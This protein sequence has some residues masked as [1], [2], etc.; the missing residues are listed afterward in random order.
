MS[1][2][3]P[4]REIPSPPLRKTTLVPNLPTVMT[5][6]MV[7][8]AREERE[9]GQIAKA[10]REVYERERRERF[11]AMVGGGVRP[12][13]GVSVGVGGGRGFEGM[14]MPMEGVSSGREERG[15]ELGWGGAASGAVEGKG[16]QKVREMEFGMAAGSDAQ[17]VDC[18]NVNGK[19][20][21]MVERSKSG[22]PMRKKIKMMGSG[23]Q[24]TA[25]GG[26]T[27]GAGEGEQLDRFK[28]AGDTTAWMSTV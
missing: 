7:Q 26:I 9:R 25:A 11:V 27:R 18:R 16:K 8:R 15:G 23:S 24:K 10:E 14:A 28:V 4:T 2:Q 5:P 22:E 12:R 13:L 3:P 20:D 19:D 17:R 1:R 6:A 21:G